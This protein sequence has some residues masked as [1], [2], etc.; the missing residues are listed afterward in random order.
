MNVIS[1][2]KAY[3]RPTTN[4][5]RW[6]DSFVWNW[7][8]GRC[9]FLRNRIFYGIKPFVPRS[10]QIYVRQVIV[11]RQRAACG[12]VWPIDERAA[13]KPAG[14]SGWPK[15]HQFAFV[16][17]HDVDSARGQS[18]CSELM[19][20]EKKM[21]FRSLFSFV[22]EDYDVSAVLRQNLVRNGFEVGV[23]GLKHDGKLFVSKKAFARQAVRINHY[24]KAWES[25]GFVSPSMHHNLNWM[26]QLNIAYDTSTF[27]TDPFEP[28]PDGVGTIFPFVV[29][30]HNGRAGYI[31]LPYTLPQDFTLFVLMQ[32]R[33]ID[34]WKRKLDWI[35]ERGGMALLITHPDYMNCNDGRTQEEYPMAFYESLLT[36][37]KHTYKGQYWHPLPKEIARFWRQNAAKETGDAKRQDFLMREISQIHERSVRRIH[38]N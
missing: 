1:H 5:V 14:W 18:K 25:V 13:K 21:G 6:Q 27:D 10:L 23:H 28:Q 26:H 16:L 15:R 36:Y 20:L 7:L 30:G 19:A 29:S 35:A 31:E 38:G 37:V 2:D 12:S 11:K 4:P 8:S 3:A 17:M 22:P 32:E 24:L 34:I 33:N 9:R